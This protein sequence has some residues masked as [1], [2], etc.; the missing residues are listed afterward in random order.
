MT[1]MIVV[2]GGVIVKSVLVHWLTRLIYNGHGLQSICI[3]LTNRFTISNCH[4]TDD[5][6]GWVGG[7]PA[8]R[9]Q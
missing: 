7:L 8:A 4:H 3:W 6:G 1:V 2:R 5:T 9:A